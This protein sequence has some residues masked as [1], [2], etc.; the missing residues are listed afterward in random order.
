MKNNILLI[1]VLALLV[2]CK[3][4]PI[5]SA[6]KILADEI[7][8]RSDGKL[9]LSKIVSHLVLIDEK[10]IFSAQYQI[11]VQ[12]ISSAPIWTNMIIGNN[13]EGQLSELEVHEDSKSVRR[14]MLG[15]ASEPLEK[16]I[17]IAKGEQYPYRI[18]LTIVKVNNRWMEI[19]DD[20]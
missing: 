16:T 19:N 3:S 10:E 18:E 11:Q 17:Q 8:K 14:P 4:S 7:L 13:N 9:K 6:N 15:M 20:L 1:L 2:G 5:D 12:S